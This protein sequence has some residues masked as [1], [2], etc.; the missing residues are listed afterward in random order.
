MW[1]LVILVVYA[2]FPPQITVFVPPLPSTMTQEE[3][4]ARAPLAL[5]LTQNVFERETE[6]EPFRL[7]F[8]CLPDKSPNA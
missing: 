1:H 2:V 4:E 3:C 7:Q 6:H 8:L 5:N